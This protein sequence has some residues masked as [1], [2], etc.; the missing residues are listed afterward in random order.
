MKFYSP[1][2]RKFHA[3][4]T[5][6][7]L[8]L[9]L[10][11]LLAVAPSSAD[12]EGFDDES[13]YLKLLMAVDRSFALPG[14]YIVVFN[15]SLVEDLQEALDELRSQADDGDADTSTGSGLNISI[16]VEREFPRLKMA[17]ITLG[18]TDDDASNADEEILMESRRIKLLS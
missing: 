6:V 7:L 4:A 14:N 12:Q 11:L 15:S 2:G 16:A 17:K 8:L 13:A 5:A 3:L 1:A 10:L 18:G 9:L